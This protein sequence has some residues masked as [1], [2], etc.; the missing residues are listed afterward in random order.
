MPPMAPWLWRLAWTYAVLPLVLA[1]VLISSQV[2]RHGFA[3]GAAAALALGLRRV[4]LT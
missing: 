1:L 2:C 4:R 3:N